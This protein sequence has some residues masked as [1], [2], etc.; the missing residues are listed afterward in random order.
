MQY[1]ELLAP[2]KNKEIGIAAIDCGADAVYIAG[3][4]FGARKAAGNNFDDI[5]ELC[6]YA[7]S[8]GVRIFVTYNTLFRE[9][10]REEVHR[11]ML[12]AQEAGADAFIIRDSSICAWSDITIPLHASTQCA[13]RDADRARYYESLGCSRLVLERELSLAQIKEIAGAVSC[14]L[15]FFV[16]GALCVCYSGDCLLSEYIDG[17]SADRGECIQACRSLYDLEDADGR[18]L[19]QRKALLSLKDYNLKSRLS[20]LA[21]AGICSFKIE[22]RLK[23]ISYVRNVVRDYDL[24]LNELVSRHP[25]LY[26]RSSFGRING[27][28]TPD[29]NKTFN[30]GYTQLWIDGKRG[31]WSSMDAPKSMGEL[32]GSVTKIRRG[33]KLDTE[34]SR[35]SMCE[36]T[37][38]PAKNGLQL[39]NGDGFA[40]VCQEGVVGFRADVCE[41]MCI[42]C[43][44]IPELREGMQLYRN[45]NTAFEKNLDNQL[46]KREIPVELTLRIHGKY[47][48]DF[49][50]RTAD[51][52]EFESSFHADVDTAENTQRAESM[53]REQLSKRSGIYAFSLISIDLEVSSLPL[54]SA[55]TINSMRRLIAEDLD[56]MPCRAIAMGQAAKSLSTPAELSPMAFP[57]SFDPKTELMRTKYCVRY[58]LGLCPNHHSPSRLPIKDREN[59]AK[60]AKPL[61]ITNNSRRFALHFH[62]RECEMTVVAD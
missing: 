42:R 39:R 19:L 31:E 1:L 24:A 2:A 17:R 56:T 55:S 29:T 50:A 15:E 54:L 27:G 57:R 33:A 23:N 59:I 60:S 28:F 36:L 62:C 16:H 38:R 7:H 61:Y 8:F 11:Q 32:V 34:S 3:P 26:A 21:Q 35:T 47:T 46:C 49:R 20:E 6:Q 37:I 22:G 45:L 13:I 58:E 52:R 14:E 41:G 9:E 40:F 4:D 30:R 10:E 51:G 53:L 25:N 43:R 5:A 48:L 18:I 12:A 44:D